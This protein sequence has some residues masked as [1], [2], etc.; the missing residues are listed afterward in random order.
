MELKVL[1]QRWKV[2]LESGDHLLAQE[3]IERDGGGLTADLGEYGRKFLL[4]E[5][6]TIR[7]ICLCGALLN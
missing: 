6:F 3:L 1:A 2:P 4:F 7:T 5:T